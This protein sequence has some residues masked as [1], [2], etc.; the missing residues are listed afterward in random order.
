MEGMAL[1]I[2][3]SNWFMQPL[4]L[5]EASIMPSA[6]L[7]PASAAQRAVFAG[8]TL[9]AQFSHTGESLEPA[10]AWN[11]SSLRKQRSCQAHESKELASAAL[12]AEED[13]ASL[14]ED[15]YKGPTIHCSPVHSQPCCI[16]H[17][18]RLYVIAA[19]LVQEGLVVKQSPFQPHCDRALQVEVLPAL[20]IQ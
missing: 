12:Q 13:C 2:Q 18:V 19:L 9:L 4:Y 5:V 1:L 17:A 6:A 8:H 16:K 11:N 14:Q 10:T 3:A 7:H 20:A 15:T